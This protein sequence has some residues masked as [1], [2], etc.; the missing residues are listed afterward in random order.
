VASE[1]ASL[2]AEL[3]ARGNAFILCAGPSMQPVVDV[4]DRVEVRPAR[5]VRTG[6]V[7]VFETVDGDRLMV[8]R[9]VASVPGLPWFFHAGDA[10]G[11]RNPRIAHK[12]RVLGR[13]VLPRQWPGRDRLLGLG[14][15]AVARLERE[16]RD[17]LG[18]R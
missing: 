2:R 1:L 8:H 4:G 13:A 9:V 15:W 10:P 14:P 3:R 17:R 16:L 7:V 18:R 6:D 5:R 11:T 12:R